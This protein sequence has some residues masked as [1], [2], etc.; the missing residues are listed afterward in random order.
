MHVDFSMHALALS[1]TGSTLVLNRYGGLQVWDVATQKL[2]RKLETSNVESLLFGPDD[3]LG[4]AG[5]D[6]AAIWDITA[7]RVLHSGKGSVVQLTPE[8]TWLVLSRAPKNCSVSELESGREL[9]R[10]SCSPDHDR[11]AVAQDGKSVIGSSI[12]GA[13]V[14]AVSGSQTQ[15]PSLP[16]L[17]VGTLSAVAAARDGFVIANHDG[18]AGLVTIAAPEARPFAT[19]LTAIH[20][21]TVSRDGKLV[22]LGDSSGNV[23]I[24]ELQ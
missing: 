21:V 10:F 1:K 24:W 18:I 11:Y 5:K 9:G 6:S 14:Y 22:A 23:E 12:L 13:R 8:G 3:R 19:D 16:N 7:N 15:Y 4:V 20:A 17:G 2:S